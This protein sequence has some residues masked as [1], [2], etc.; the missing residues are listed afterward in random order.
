MAYALKLYNVSIGFAGKAASSEVVQ[1]SFP[2]G[3]GWARYAPNSWILQTSE[4]AETIATSIRAKISTSDNIVVSPFDPDTT[5]GFLQ[6][7]IWTW[8]RNA[9]VK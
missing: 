2:A 4:S 7:E 3:A 9:V 6:E 8:I 5:Y 1:G